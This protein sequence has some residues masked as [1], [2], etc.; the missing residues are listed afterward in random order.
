MDIDSETA[1]E[2]AP[3]SVVEIKNGLLRFDAPVPG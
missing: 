1:D 2:K 3:K